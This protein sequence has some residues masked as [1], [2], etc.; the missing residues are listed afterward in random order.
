MRLSYSQV[1]ALRYT[2]GQLIDANQGDLPIDTI[3]STTMKYFVDLFNKIKPNA[4]LTIASLFYFIDEQLQNT[5]IITEGDL[6]W[7][8]PNPLR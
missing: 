1:Q 7:I 2:L 8:S 3:T 5:Y 6:N 4:S